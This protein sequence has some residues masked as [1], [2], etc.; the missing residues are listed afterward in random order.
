MEKYVDAFVLVVPKK[1]LKAYKKMAQGGAKMWKKYGALEY[2]ECAGD[3]LSPKFTAVK[4]PKLAKA[5]PGETVIVSFIVY[6]SRADRDRINALIYKDPA[7]GNPDQPM[8]FD[9][10]R[11]TFGGFKVLVEG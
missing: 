2:F 7:M 1:N 11:M 5:K 9:E 8:P 3:D 10:K 4:F 6:K